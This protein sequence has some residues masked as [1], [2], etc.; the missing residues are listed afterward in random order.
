[1]RTTAALTLAGL[2][3]LVAGEGV[4]GAKPPAPPGRGGSPTPAG[5]A[6]ATGAAPGS[7]SGTMTATAPGT[8]AA[9]A[10]G[11]PPRPGDAT[12]NT[13]QE[14][15]PDELTRTSP[16]GLTADQVG[17]RAAATSYNAVAAD[18]ALRS[19]AARV[20]QA[21]SQF[22]PR[23]TGTARYTRLSKFTPP[24]LTGPVSLVGTTAPAGTSNPPTIA[25]GE[26]GFVPVLDNWLLQASI[27][28]PISDY[29][30]RIN[31]GYSAATHAQEAAR[32]DADAQRAKAY[33]DGKSAFYTWLRARYAVVVAV[34]ALNDQRTHLRDA[35]NQFNAGNASKA[36]VLRAETAAA[37]AEL[38][39]ERAKN[40]ADLAEKQVRVAIHAKD[41]EPVVPG[42]SLDGT[43]APVVGNLQ[44]MTTEALSS[45]LEIKSI[46]A[47]AEAARRQAAANRGAALPSLSGF[48]DAIYANPN[49]RIFP[50]TSTWFAT[51]DIGAQITW[52]PNDVPVALAGA[53]DY[54]A[55][56]AAL[57]AQRNATRDGVQIEVLQGWQAAKEAE[58][59]L[60][61]TKR[62]L[63]S[64]TEAYRV[65]H[66]LFNAGRG[67]STTLTDA[68]TDLT[69]A[70]LDALNAQVDARIARVRLDHVL[71]RDVREAIR[72]TPQGR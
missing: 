64:A 55:R 1:M 61:S 24:S 28:V 58:V 35:Q 18:E 3:V 21:W 27:V 59:A 62:E 2:L 39:V 51:W 6:A 48:G 8:G 26:F 54:S 37:A 47:N 9:A 68:E 71:G 19:A 7:A 33:A 49:P 66:E 36:D 4:A 31:E 15:V 45:R 67:T 10:N 50:Q 22:L 23:L 40:L 29:F 69:R 53:S 11:A 41:E 12:T 5:A 25:L 16:N 13:T 17:A 38:Q 14:R 63:A 43:A 72:A 32:A 30:L 60:D 34:Q 20:D 65:A 52:S 56:A 70:R 42:E 46:D 57:E 44:Q